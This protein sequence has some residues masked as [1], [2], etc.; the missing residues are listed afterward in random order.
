MN[1]R[2]EQGSSVTLWGKNFPPQGGLVSSIQISKHVSRL[3]YVSMWLCCT[4]NSPMCN[5]PDVPVHTPVLKRRDRLSTR[6]RERSV[7]NLCVQLN[8][9]WYCC[10]SLVSTR[11]E[12]HWSVQFS[13]L[14][15]SVL[16]F[17]NSRPW[18]ICTANQQ[19]ELTSPFQWSKSLA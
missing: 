4:R 5:G 15:C 9:Q 17:I 2:G 14:I 18:R 19:T 7:C 6:V 8:Q 10:V 12:A 11:K 3:K 16:F 13:T 1:N